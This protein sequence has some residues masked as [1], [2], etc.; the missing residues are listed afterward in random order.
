MVF[1]S[2]L[3]NFMQFKD[4][5]GYTYDVQPHQLEKFERRRGILLRIAIVIKILIIIGLIALFWVPKN[6]SSSN[7]PVLKVSNEH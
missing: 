4:G 1:G 7:K 5:F 6:E 2:F 3:G